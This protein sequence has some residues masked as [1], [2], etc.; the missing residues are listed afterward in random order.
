MISLIKVFLIWFFCMMRMLIIL[1]VLC[2]YN[3]IR[4]FIFFS[5]SFISHYIN[6]NSSSLIKAELGMTN[7]GIGLHGV[8]K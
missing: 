7:D 2:N 5:P 3:F 6:Y 1:H 8:I 4:L